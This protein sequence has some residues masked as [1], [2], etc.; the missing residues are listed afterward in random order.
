MNKYVPVP[1]EDTYALIQSAKDGDEEAKALICRQNTGLVKKIALKF[2]AGEYELD[3]LI[4]IGYIGLLKAVYKFEPGFDVMFSTYAVPMI[5]GELKRFFRDNGKIKVSRS[6]K[7]EIYTMKKIE[8]QFQT[9]EG[10]APRLSDM[11]EEMGITVEH[12]LEVMEASAVLSNVGSLDNRTEMEEYSAYNNYASPESNIDGILLREKIKELDE[13]QRRVILLRYY[14]D[15]TQQ[16]I[17][18]ILGISQVQVSRT[19]KKAL[20]IIREKIEKQ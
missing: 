16:E 19:E 7:S 8:N 10:S 17:A 12:L 1:K 13:K 5:L 20:E 2:T 3:D 9:A 4:Q 14:R 6:L 18:K 15:L 11:A